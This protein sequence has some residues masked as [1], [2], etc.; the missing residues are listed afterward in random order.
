LDEDTQFQSLALMVS[1]E[2]TKTEQIKEWD[3]QL[4]RIDHRRE[5]VIRDLDKLL[6]REEEKLRAI[7]LKKCEDLK[8]KIA[9]EKQAFEEKIG[10]ERDELLAK[11]E[12]VEA[13]RDGMRKRIKLEIGSE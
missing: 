4:D 9:R 6:A 11:K 8:R 13:E 10:R 1:E 12:D 5:Q 2:R 7:Y 3:S